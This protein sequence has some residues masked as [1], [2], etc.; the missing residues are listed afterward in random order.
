MFLG[1]QYAQYATDNLGRAFCIWVKLSLTPAEKFRIHGALFR[2]HIH[3]NALRHQGEESF[4]ARPNMVDR[5]VD[6]ALHRAFYM[7]HAPW[8]N[9][10]YAFVYQYITRRL[11]QGTP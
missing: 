6:D 2:H 4:R 8:V 10:Q 1:E 3:V 9:R 5:V 7:V 11:K